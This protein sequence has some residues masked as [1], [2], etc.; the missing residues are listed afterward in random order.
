MREYKSQCARHKACPPSVRSIYSEYSTP[1][2]SAH[3]SVPQTCIA[4]LKQHTTRGYLHLDS[5]DMHIGST[6]A[7]I[8]NKSPPKTLFA[9]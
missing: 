8:A 9:L 3:L 2:V 5:I 1:K 4:D 7:M 6:I